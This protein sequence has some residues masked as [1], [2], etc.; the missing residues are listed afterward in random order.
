MSRCRGYQSCLGVLRLSHAGR[1][2]KQTRRDHFYF[3]SR[4]IGTYP[5]YYISFQVWRWTVC[6]GSTTFLRPGFFLA[7]P[8]VL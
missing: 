8:K 4:G 6:S 2:Y 5:A 1:Y 7:W 3:K